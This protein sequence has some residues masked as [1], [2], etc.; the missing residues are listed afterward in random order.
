MA[1]ELIYTSSERGLR[2]GTSG[3]CTVAYTKGLPAQKIPLLEALSGYRNAYAFQEGKSGREPVSWCH[4]RSPLFGREV[5][6]LSRISAAGADHTGRS[7]KL[8]HHVLVGESERAMG[9]P[10]W[11]SLQPGFFRET[12]NEEPHCFEEPKFLPSGDFG[13]CRARCWEAL[14]GDGGHAALLAENVNGDDGRV[15][16]LLFEPGMD[17]LPL[18]G[19]AMALLPWH[20]RW[21]VTYNTYF[22]ALPAG[23]LCTWRCC[24]AGSDAAREVRRNPRAMVID[25]TSPLPPVE[26]TPMAALAREGRRNG[27]KELQSVSLTL[28]EPTTAPPPPQRLSLRSE[29]REINML[30]L[31]PRQYR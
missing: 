12:W 23:M 5:S 4:Y 22:T 21:R 25:L 13:D 27:Q 1:Y 24:L 31:K 30:T 20:V 28:E 2:P 10:A 9:G 16:V 17:M 14:T 18:I 6:V 15:V 29:S 26:D 19:E 7:N 11:V 8:A 3:F